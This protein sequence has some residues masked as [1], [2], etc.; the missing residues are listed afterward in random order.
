MNETEIES[1][2]ARLQERILV[3]VQ[4]AERL[5][6]VEVQIQRIASDLESEKGTRARV[7]EKVDS[8]LETLTNS[9][10]ALNKSNW[11]AAGAV[12]AAFV[13]WD[14]LKHFIKF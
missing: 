14:V 10:N 8:K 6:T 4:T 1:V 5:R 2:A 12:G 13:L 9:I 7:N 11:T 3:A